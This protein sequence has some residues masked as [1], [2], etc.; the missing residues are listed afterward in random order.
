MFM[1]L[2]TSSLIVS[3]NNFVIDV[4]KVL[5]LRNKV[6][7]D[8]NFNTKQVHKCQVSSPTIFLVTL[9]ALSPN[10]VS[11]GPVSLGGEI[12]LGN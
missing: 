11:P 4:T 1:F 6:H 8:V 2:F 5:R 9:L 12:M 7:V 3:E 10:V